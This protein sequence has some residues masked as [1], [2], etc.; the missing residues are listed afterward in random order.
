MP[1]KRESTRF[2]RFFDG[3]SR[4]EI[5][6]PHLEREMLMRGREA[7]PDEYPI[8][9]DNKE[10]RFD[11]YFHPSSDAAAPPLFLYYKFHDAM[12][13]EAEVLSTDLLLTFQFGSA[14]H[15]ILQSLLVECG[16]T[17]VE[18]CEVSFKDE[19]RWC[20]GH[21]DVRRLTMPNIEPMPVEIKSWGFLPK[22]VVPYHEAQMQVYMDLADD[23]PY[24]RGLV[25]YAQK[26]SPHRLREFVVERNEDML[27][28]IYRKWRD[29]LEA[30]ALNDPSRFETCT[31]CVPNN[32]VHFECPARNICR[33]G[34]PGYRKAG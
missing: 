29:V 31:G 19:K 16:F 24:Q 3:I 34:P 2:R 28:E 6:V 1:S 32:K 14:L 22:Q 13:L 12:A 33:I 4:R 30:V 25:L 20:S 18:E 7:W 15:A 8:K 26:Q 23:E 17:T 27:T 10:K 9:V 5:L 11:G 21:V